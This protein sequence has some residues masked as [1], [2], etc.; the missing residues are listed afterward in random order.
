MKCEI[1]KNKIEET[2]LKKISGTFVK[3]SKGK[4]HIIC[5]D[6]QKKYPDKE[7]LLKKL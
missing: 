2:F 7:E 1:C 3:D 6:C 5:N 4:K